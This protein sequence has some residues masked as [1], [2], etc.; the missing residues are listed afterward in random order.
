MKNFKF[1]DTKKVDSIDFN[2]KLKAAALTLVLAL[3]I[4]G[5]GGGS[6]DTVTPFRVTES[7]D[8]RAIATAIDSTE[9]SVVTSGIF[10]NTRTP[11]ESGSVAPAAEANPGQG[12][13]VVKHDNKG[14]KVWDT[15]IRDQEWNSVAHM[16]IDGSDGS[17]VVVGHTGPLPIEDAD[18]TALDM[19]DNAV[20][21][22][23]GVQPIGTRPGLPLGA[24]KLNRSWLV[25]KLDKDGNELFRRNWRECFPDTYDYAASEFLCTCEAKHVAIGSSGNIYIAGTGGS[26][27]PMEKVQL[28][29]YNSS[30]DVLW[31][32][33]RRDFHIGPLDT[34]NI[35][36]AEPIDATSETNGLA[37]AAQYKVSN[38][39]TARL[40][41]YGWDLDIDSSG[42][43]EVVYATVP[44]E[45]KSL[46]GMLAIDESGD[47][48]ASRRTFFDDL[49]TT[50][51]PINSDRLLVGGQIDNPDGGDNAQAS[52]DLIDGGLNTVAS[53]SYSV[54]DGVT[55]DMV[56]PQSDSVVA[57]A[58]ILGIA[59]K[60]VSLFRLDGID[61]DQLNIAW[62][63]LYSSTPLTI[64][65]LDGILESYSVDNGQRLFQNSS[66]ELILVGDA[67]RTEGI[68][69]IDMPAEDF[70]EPLIT[71]GLSS[72]LFGF[73]PL[74]SANFN[75][76][77]NLPDALHLSILAADSLRFEV[78]LDPDS[79]EITKSK[80]VMSEELSTPHVIAQ[81]ENG[82]L[83][84]VSRSWKYDDNSL[85]SINIIQQ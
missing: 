85:R 80:G 56:Q 66:G 12:I 27:W 84:R 46:R 30:G 72:K 54:F 21:K 13:F 78:K 18:L 43:E 11:L 48:V 5:C 33:L 67:L 23:E 50:I 4:V 2:N 71:G 77:L 79:G 9:D 36:F 26:P 22:D 63:N 6:S 59:N 82:K 25:V 65:V 38:Y 35:S 19:F 8:N 29:A 34:S 73:I 69:E 57:A 68:L 14:D 76:D 83:V 10:I 15:V 20:A 39:D 16:A 70:V 52:V 61:G 17:I 28:V 74:L 62:D 81:R 75:V 51:K 37:D 7:Y 55:F 32:E 60:D 3:P 49:I 53:Y 42:A 41:H 64:P 40:F 44:T 45:T 31:D 24:A 47:L 58:N 1:S